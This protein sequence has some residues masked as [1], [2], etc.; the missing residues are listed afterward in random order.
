[1]VNDKQHPVFLLAMNTSPTIKDVG[2]QDYMSQLS[3]DQA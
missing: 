3:V 2:F 1:M